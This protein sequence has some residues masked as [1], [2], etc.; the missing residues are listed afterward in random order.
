MPPVD[1]ARHFV[2][3]KV[4]GAVTA[5]SLAAKTAGAKTV[6]AKSPGAG[7]SMDGGRT[8]AASFSHIDLAVY[9]NESTPCR[10]VEET[11]TYDSNKSLEQ[12]EDEIADAIASR[13]V[14]ALIPM[15]RSR[16]RE[17]R[18]GRQFGL[19][20]QLLAVGAGNMSYPIFSPEDCEQV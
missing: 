19:Y 18:Y 16:V 3:H 12:R 1:P 14:E 9:L 7:R 10:L 20:L 13:A 17:T 15:L 5:P 11:T 8:G 4:A 6:G 2:F